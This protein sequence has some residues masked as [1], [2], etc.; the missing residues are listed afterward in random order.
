MTSPLSPTRR[1]GR[2]RTGIKMMNAP[3][4]S[5][6]ILAALVL[7]VASLGAFAGRSAAE[8]GERHYLYVATPG[9][10]DYLQYGGHGLLVFDIDAGHRFVKRIP[11]RGLEENGRPDNVKGI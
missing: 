8:D 7:F 6:R 4:S 2:G 5:R 10:R 11:F 1:P 9:I 3:A